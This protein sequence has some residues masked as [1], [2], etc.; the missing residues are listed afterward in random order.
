MT[1]DERDMA[2]RMLIAAL[3]CA[4]EML[5][6]VPQPEPETGYPGRLRDAAIS[7][8]VPDERLGE[9]QRFA[10][11]LRF[12]SDSVRVAERNNRP[13]LHLRR[14]RKSLWPNR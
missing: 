14:E 11:A 13:M 7:H 1:S 2:V 10:G 8:G 5:R 12:F 4:G 9:V 3:Q 6:D